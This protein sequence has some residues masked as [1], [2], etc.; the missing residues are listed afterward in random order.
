M[1]RGYIFVKLIVTIVEEMQASHKDRQ[2]TIE[3]L[4]KLDVAAALKLLKT[5]VEMTQNLHKSKIDATK[6]LH[7]S[8]VA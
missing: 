2:V 8:Q 7:K 3:A 6:H 4:G 1:I 5:Q